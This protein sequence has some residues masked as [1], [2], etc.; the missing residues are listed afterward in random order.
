VRVVADTGPLHDRVLMGVVDVRPRLFG[1][2]VI[3]L[4]VRGGRDRSATPAAVRTWIQAPPPFLSI[5]SQS[6]HEDVLPL[7]ALD[8]GERAAIA[9]ATTLR[10]DLLLMDDR[11]GVAAAR[12]RGFAVTGAVGLLDR[13]ARRGLIDLKGAVIR[14]Q[15]SSFQVS[16][17]LIERRLASR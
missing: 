12:S 15:A 4:A 16:P 1:G 9:R 6:A 8:D 2:V 11:A 3:P 14:L 13:A 10:A 17:A 5:A 7:P